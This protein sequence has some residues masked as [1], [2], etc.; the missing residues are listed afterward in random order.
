MAISFQRTDLRGTAAKAIAPHTHP[1]NRIAARVISPTIPISTHLNPE[2][3]SSSGSLAKF[4]A[5]RREAA[6]GGGTGSSR[7]DYGATYATATPIFFR[8]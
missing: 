1:A 2:K 7:V 6:R 3:R 5:M 4:A 8:R